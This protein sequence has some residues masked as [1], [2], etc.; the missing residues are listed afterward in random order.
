MK[1]IEPTTAAQLPVV[2]SPSTLVMEP[3][4]GGFRFLLRV[5]QLV[6]FSYIEMTSDDFI[7]VWR[8]GTIILFMIVLGVLFMCLFM[9]LC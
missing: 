1:N 4:G 9:F 5:T 6:F 3:A 8:E 7:P 2:F